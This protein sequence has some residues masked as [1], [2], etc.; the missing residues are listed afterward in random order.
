MGGL[1]GF[2]AAE[3]GLSMVTFHR[4]PLRGCN[5]QPTAPSY[6]TI[7]NLL[8]DYASTQLAQ[9]V[10]PYVAIAHADGLQFR[11]DEMNSVACSGKKTVSDT[12]AAGL[13]ML[14][15]L[16]EMAAA[17]VDGVNVHTLPNSIYELFSFTHDQSGWHALVHP[18]YYGML[19]FARADPVGARLLPV[20]GSGG[21]VKVWATLAPDGTRRVLLINKDPVSAHNVLLTM[22]AGPLT[23]TVENF[24]APNASA[25][26]DVTIGGQ[27][28]GGAAVAASTDTGTLAGHT[29]STRVLT[30]AGIYE[31]TLPPASA[32]L[33][34][35]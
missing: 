27:S 33:L 8:S 14:D 2:L 34:T 24:S 29:Q 21:Q 20:S 26:S 18:D 17:G 30:P 25:T 11:L 23:A 7:S 35:Q 32:Q 10:A 12:F 13:W 22:P 15:T 31:T 19:M 3:P 6:A 4:Y 1:S 16:F 28:F 9:G 5:V